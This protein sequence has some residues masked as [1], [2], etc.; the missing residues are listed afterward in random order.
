[1]ND[2]LDDYDPNR[3]KPKPLSSDDYKPM[4]QEGEEA[5]NKRQNEPLFKKAQDM[6]PMEQVKEHFE[7]LVCGYNKRDGCNILVRDK[8]FYCCIYHQAIQAIGTEFM[9]YWKLIN[10]NEMDRMTPQ[11]HKR[12]EERYQYNVRWLDNFPRGASTW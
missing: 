9:M 11:Q 7:N 5:Y 12:L 1:M 6:I 8:S 3:I 10:D 4:S 2:N